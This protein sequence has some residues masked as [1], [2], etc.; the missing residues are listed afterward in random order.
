M[1]WR[2]T[3]NPAG[4]DQIQFKHIVMRY[5]CQAMHTHLYRN[6]IDSILPATIS[7]YDSCNYARLRV[8]TSDSWPCE[9]PPVQFPGTTCPAAFV[10]VA[11]ARVCR[12]GSASAL[13]QDRFAARW[14]LIRV[15]HTDQTITDRY[16]SRHFWRGESVSEVSVQ[17]QEPL[18]LHIRMRGFVLSGILAGTSCLLCAS[19]PNVL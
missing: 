10:T 18:T 1:P 3:V 13:T 19:W 6:A 12:N 5:I 2:W 15:R 9:D 7:H 8:R 16:L 14:V 4:G 17:T 11:C